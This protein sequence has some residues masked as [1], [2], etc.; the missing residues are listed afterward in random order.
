MTGLET[1]QGSGTVQPAARAAG[2]GRVLVIAQDAQ[3]IGPV[4]RAVDHLGGPEPLVLRSQSDVLEA[5]VANL[6]DFVHVLIE[7]TALPIEQPLIDAL[8]E[9]SPRARIT[10][11]NLH[12]VSSEDGGF[13]VGVLAGTR[14]LA[15]Q[16]R[17]PG[18][19]DVPDRTNSE[20][21]LLRYQPIVDSRTRRLVMVEALARW[22]SEPV[23]LTPMNFVPA[24]EQMGLSRLL[25]AAVTRIA[26]RDLARMGPRVHI[27]VSVNLPAS[28]LEKRDVADWIGR[29]IRRA[30]L[31]R[32]RLAIELTETMP[33]TD[34]S[35][36]ARSLQRLTAGGHQI[37]LDDLL[38]DDSRLRLLSLP[39][40]G[41]KLDRSLVMKLPRS[42]RARQLV[43]RLTRQGIAMTA[44][45][46]STA[47]QM[48]QLRHL[49]VARVQGFGI[50]RPLPIGAL[51]AWNERW[52]GRPPK[53]FQP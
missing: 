4:I 53:A 40:H 30:R 12:T 43:L 37:F 52:R 34:R 16:P 11:L 14:D 48:R 31:P 2:R 1:R 10:A 49:G 9:A 38:L 29:E 28:E 36:L 47:A 42:A 27:P 5:V 50:G 46:V 22:R 18:R 15:H 6:A 24:M 44:E 41:V 33:V 20:R 19:N 25:A 39:F 51:P 8:A 23:A 32:R 3:L 35:R 7:D 17:M 21:L 13:L 26:A 45:G